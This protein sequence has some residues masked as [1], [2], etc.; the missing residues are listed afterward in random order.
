M[1]DP[2][3]SHGDTPGRGAA[4]SSPHPLSLAAAD[5]QLAVG[6]AGPDD[7]RASEQRAALLRHSGCDPDLADAPAVVEA[8][9]LVGGHME[10]EEIGAAIGAAAKAAEA[11]AGQPAEAAEFDISKMSARLS[12]AQHDLVWPDDE[13]G[14]VDLSSARWLDAVSAD[15]WGRVTRLA[16]A[17][18]TSP[19][20]LYAALLARLGPLLGPGV[21]HADPQGGPDLVAL[22]FHLALLGPPGAGKSAAADGAEY[23]LP[24]P[25]P[26]DDKAETS[27]AE[28]LDPRTIN[29]PSGVG[30]IRACR[31]ERPGDKRGDP[32]V[33]SRVYGLLCYWPEGKRLERL[34]AGTRSPGSDIPDVLRQAWAGEELSSDASDAA[35]RLLPVYGHVVSSV[36]CC[37]PS[38]GAGILQDAESNEGTWARCAVLPATPPKVPTKAQIRAKWPPRLTQ[39]ADAKGWRP[40]T[41]IAIPVAD[42]VTAEFEDHSLA[43]LAFELGD[44]TQADTLLPDWWPLLYH[45]P[46]TPRLR[47][48]AAALICVLTAG[49]AAG[50]KQTGGIARAHWDAAGVLLQVSARTRALWLAFKAEHD[51]AR[52]RAKGRAKAEVETAAVKPGHARINQIIDTFLGQIEKAAPGTSWTAS[53]WSNKAAGED[54]ATAKQLGREPVGK[55]LMAKAKQEGLVEKKGRRWVRR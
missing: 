49:A 47:L 20:A 35:R 45:G 33:M 38:V 19:W 40:D 2:H 6:L 7:K 32:P 26:V 17:K 37:Q 21:G 36:V 18:R 42:D 48:R 30:I 39:R 14:E 11:A 5:H 52:N 3:P 10:P 43:A 54:R 55:E 29:P 1:T 25:R 53:E 8:A 15:V 13:M 44:A 16:A 27:T 24:Y 9:L 51:T 22:S 31:H 23:L 46:H 41:T 50:A 12:K 34:L 28:V 4:D